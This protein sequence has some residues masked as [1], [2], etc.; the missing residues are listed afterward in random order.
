[1]VGN[2]SLAREG[3]ITIHVMLRW[4]VK[5]LI[6]GGFLVKQK[7]NPGKKKS[8]SCSEKTKKRLNI[9]HYEYAA[10]RPQKEGKI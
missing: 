4:G 7:Q 2:L 5:R 6:Y 9:D 1:M 3:G 8:K 10:V